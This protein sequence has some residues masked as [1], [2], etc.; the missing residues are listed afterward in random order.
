MVRESGRVGREDNVT[1]P[2]SR[3]SLN[4]LRSIFG[5]LLKFPG[6]SGILQGKLFGSSWASRSIGPYYLLLPS[7]LLSTDGPSPF[8]LSWSFRWDLKRACR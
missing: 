3:L 7:L 1:I 2:S 5:E 6:L 8:S 4:S